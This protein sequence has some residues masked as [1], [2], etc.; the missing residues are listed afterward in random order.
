LLFED[1]KKDD[2]VF[3]FYLGQLRCTHLLAA[4]PDPTGDPA[5]FAFS[6]SGPPS[7]AASATFRAARTID[8]VLP[9]SGH[10]NTTADR[11]RQ[12]PY[13]IRDGSR[14]EDRVLAQADSIRARRLKNGL[15][16][17]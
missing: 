1:G 6:R 8:A 17:R 15:E 3:I 5:I 9:R 4:R 16:N 13:D 2:A 14:H 11:V 12:G 7:R 10:H